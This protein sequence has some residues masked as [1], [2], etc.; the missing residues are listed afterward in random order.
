LAAGGFGSY[1]G[2]IIGGLLTGL[3]AEFAARSI[4]A[5]YQQM[6]VF[7]LLLLILVVRPRGLLSQKEL[8]RA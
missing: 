2:S 5:N 8:R 4:G 7:A 3:A 6:V 1:L